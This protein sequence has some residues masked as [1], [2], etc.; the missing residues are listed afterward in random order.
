MLA[1]AR[2]LCTAKLKS[3]KTFGVSVE[4]VKTYGS[5]LVDSI[6]EPIVNSD[7]VENIENQKI[8]YLKV[9]LYMVNKDTPCSRYKSRGLKVSPS[10]MY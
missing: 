5:N 7:C 2:I 9:L 10:G 4:K 6:D 1:Y 8:S 3:R